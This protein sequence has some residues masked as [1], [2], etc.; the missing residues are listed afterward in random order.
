MQI[1]DLGSRRSPRSPNL[2]VKTTHATQVQ[3]GSCASHVVDISHFYFR[4][5]QQVTSKGRK[6]LPPDTNL[7]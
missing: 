2:E 3:V 7:V 1:W 6:K 5:P 4:D